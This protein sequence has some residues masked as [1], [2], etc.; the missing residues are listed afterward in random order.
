MCRSACTPGHDSARGRGATTAR[1][2]W[3]RGQEDPRCA[4][5]ERHGNSR[6]A[7]V[8]VLSGESFQFRSARGGATV[9]PCSGTAR[10]VS[11][12][13]RPWRV[14]ERE[15]ERARLSREVRVRERAL[16]LS[17]EGFMERE[18]LSRDR[19]PSGSVVAQLSRRDVVL[20]T[21]AETPRV[22]Q[23]TD[24]VDRDTDA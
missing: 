13:V 12:R 15:R 10:G 5:G 16:S 8:S 2:C 11:E 4:R 22:V 19:S 18:D 1:V 3:Q 17:R 20:Y 9:G 14:R 6:C 24:R 23:N 7:R 21:A